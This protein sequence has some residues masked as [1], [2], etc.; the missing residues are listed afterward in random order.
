MVVEEVKL[1]LEEEGVDVVEVEM[2]EEVEV[3]MVNE[4][5]V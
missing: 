4:E 1:E 2:V 5:V 3:E